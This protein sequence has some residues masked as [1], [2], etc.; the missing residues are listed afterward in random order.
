MA[1]GFNYVSAQDYHG[2]RAACLIVVFWVAVWNLVEEGV[3]W[4]E[5]TYGWKRMHVYMALLG[6]VVLFIVFDPYTFEGLVD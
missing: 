4:L 6:F 3:A 2:L 1:K 5:Q